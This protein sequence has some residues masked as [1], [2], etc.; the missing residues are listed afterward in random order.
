MIFIGENI[1]IVPLEK[2]DL[3]A[4]WK[5]REHKPILGYFEAHRQYYKEAEKLNVDPFI[6]YRNWTL[7][8]MY[9]SENWHW[10]IY[11][12]SPTKLIG[13]VWTTEVD[14]KCAWPTFLMGREVWGKGYTE[15]VVKTLL[16]AFLGPSE[17]DGKPEGGYSIIKVFCH[18]ANRRAQALAKGSGFKETGFIPDGD[19]SDGPM[20]QIIFSLTQKEWRNRQPKP[21]KPKRKRGRPKK[22]EL[23][24]AEVG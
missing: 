16:G 9:G 1:V 21:E 22:K 4:V 24:T 15:D 10:G 14:D 12:K 7:S 23:E 2:A 13:A 3:P 11:S 17:M 20:D 18:R 5:F 6:L 19:G 8:Q